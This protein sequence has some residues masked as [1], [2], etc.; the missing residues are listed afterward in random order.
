MK[1]RDF[2]GEKRATL[3]EYA[4]QLWKMSEMAEMLACD[5]P[6][7]LDAEYCNNGY[8]SEFD[9]ANYA[10]TFMSEASDDLGE[11]AQIVEEALARLD[12]A[13]H[14]CNAFA[15]VL[16]WFLREDEF[17]TM[18]DVRDAR[19]TAIEMLISAGFSEKDAQ[20]H[21]ENVKGEVCKQQDGYEE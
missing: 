10:W 15:E 20:A 2:I 9:D 1:T 13:E 18:R 6:V 19:K 3:R 8:R 5:I 17:T 21:V 11:T 7:E 14:Y 4:A 16:G 12:D